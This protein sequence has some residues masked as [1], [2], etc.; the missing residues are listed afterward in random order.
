LA[1]CRIVDFSFCRLFGEKRRQLSF[2]R[3][4]VFSKRQSNYRSLIS[5]LC[6]SSF[7]LYFVVLLTFRFLVLSICRLFAHYRFVVLSS[8]RCDKT[9]RRQIVDWH[10]SATIV[11]RYTY[12]M[13]ILDD[14]QVAVPCC[15]VY[16]FSA[17]ARYSRGGSHD[18]NKSWPIHKLILILFSL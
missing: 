12:R 18:V 3:S 5:W 15:C 7:R 9:K 13:L 2:C 16:N 6:L 11:K 8:F 4:V 14:R 10:K 17:L 1:F